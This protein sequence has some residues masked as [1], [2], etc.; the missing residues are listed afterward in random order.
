M[1]CLSLLLPALLGAQTSRQLADLNWMEFR[2]LVPSKIQ[3]VLLPTGTLEAHGVINN[4]ADTTAPA[5]LAAGMAP[6]LNA[7]V[8]PA[9]PYG[10]TGN[11]DA[12][13]RQLSP[14]APQPT[15]PT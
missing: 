11:L 1:R 12:V 5:D 10:L 9:V 14:S 2:E 13:R 8:A 15:A 7:L 3:T 4:G 6:R